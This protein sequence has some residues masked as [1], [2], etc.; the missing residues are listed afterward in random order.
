MKPDPTP[1]LGSRAHLPLD[2]ARCSPTRACPQRGICA[3][4]CDWPADIEHL[5]VIDASITFG[6]R[7]SWCPMFIDVRGI[8]LRAAA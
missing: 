8:D 6:Q 3:R 5:P 2:V 4:A 1:A 7:G